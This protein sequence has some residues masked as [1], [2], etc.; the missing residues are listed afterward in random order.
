MS[1]L[2]A[3]IISARCAQAAGAASAAMSVSFLL[4]IS[5]LF[6][7]W[8]ISS[9]ISGGSANPLPVVWWW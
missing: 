9:L 6:P 3:V 7:Q 5:P 4:T 8:C 2:V 1:K